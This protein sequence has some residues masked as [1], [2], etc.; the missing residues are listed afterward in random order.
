LLSFIFFFFGKNCYSLSEENGPPD[1]LMFKGELSG[2]GIYSHNSSLSVMAGG[3][4]IPTLNYGLDFK[5]TRKL[6][7]EGSLN[8]YGSVATHPFDTVAFNGDIAAYRAWIRYSTRQWELR[9]GLQ[10]ISFGSATL[11]RP[12]MWFDQ[13]DPRDPLQLTNGVWGLLSRYYFRNNANLWIWGLLGNKQQRPWDI[14]KTNQWIPEAGGR[15]QYPIPKG[16][17]ALSYH[18][19]NVDTQDLSPTITGEE[20]VPENRFGFDGKIDLKVSLWLEGTWIHK[21][22]PTGIYTNQEILTAGI[23][24]TFGI[25]NG[26]YVL[27]EQMLYSND[28]HAFDFN[29]TISFSGISL[30]YPIGIV[31]NL[32]AIIYYDW[33]NNNAYNFINWSHQF[34]HVRFYLMAYWNPDHYNLPQSR[35]MS[36][37]YAGPGLQVMVVY[38]H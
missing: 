2:W 1:T 29:N 12:L 38:N 24:Y 35:D 18:Y 22:Q 32:S 28:E 17:V 9:L 19:R 10:K 16:E 5:N 21:S 3:R 31:D 4:Y 34:R 33:N 23:D 13:I 8:I 25:G 26:L 20:N 6:D 27:A 30:S 36:E 7:M 11:L 15:F 14:G 37:T